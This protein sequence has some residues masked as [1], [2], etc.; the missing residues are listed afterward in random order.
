[1]PAERSASAQ[2]AEVAKSGRE[3]TSTSLGVESTSMKSIV[4]TIATL[5]SMSCVAASQVPEQEKFT[6]LITKVKRVND[7]CVAEGESTKVRFRFSS[8]ISAPC[9][10]LRAGESYK[11]IRGV[12]V[13]DSADETK[14]QTIL[15]IYDNVKNVRRDNGGFNIDS[16]EAIAQK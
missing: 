10:M 15:V 13:R 11:A 12:A 9:A 4:L 8:D 2:Y 6:L 5:F 14:D 1:V 3:R 16:E 7:G